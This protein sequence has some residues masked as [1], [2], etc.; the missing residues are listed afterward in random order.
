M[1]R[2][3]KWLAPGALLFPHEHDE[4]IPD[5]KVVERLAQ[6]ED[7]LGDDYDLD[8]LE[9]MMNQC[10]S[11]REEVSERFRITG[12][13]PVK[14][15]RELVEADKAGRCLVLQVKP[16]DTVR[17]AKNPRAKQEKVACVTLYEAGKIRLGF[18][19]VGYKE[20]WVDEWSEDDAENYVLA[21]EVS[22]H[23]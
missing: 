13:I 17:F 22:D 16:G 12:S 20:T 8:R 11:M 19:D 6:I 23:E 10:M 18:H 9:V 5:S 3:T 7:I 14:R 21:S 4:I 15:L 1:K 2:L